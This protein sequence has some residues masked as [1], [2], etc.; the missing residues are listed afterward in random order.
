MSVKNSSTTC[1]GMEWEEMLGLLQ[2]LKRDERYSDYLLIACGCFFGL[3]IKDL[4]NLKWQDVMDNTEFT[5]RESKTGKR[6]TITLNPTIREIINFVYDKRRI[7]K[8]FS[9]KDFLFVNRWKR[10]LSVQYVNR[11]L[12]EIFFRYNLRVKNGSS[13]IL[14]KTFGKRVWEMDGQSER[15]LIYLSE[16]YGHGALSTTKRYIGISHQNIQNIYLNL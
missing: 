3:R 12:H 15:S 14:R 4:L 2:R 11:R 10:K 7:E 13:H 6:R 8:D 16:V 5:L 1:T 9:K